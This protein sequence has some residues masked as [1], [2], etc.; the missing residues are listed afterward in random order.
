M[1]ITV[2]RADDVARRLTLYGRQLR[3][4]RS[5]WRLVARRVAAEERVW[6]A[7]EGRG[8]WAPLSKEYAAW[9]ARHYPGRPILVATGELRAAATS[10]ERLLSDR[11]GSMMT[12]RID[13]PKAAYHGGRQR[14][15]LLPRRDPSVPVAT[16]RRIAREAMRDHV[17]YRAGIPGPKPAA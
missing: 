1:R 14:S 8:T 5:L 2:T 3:T 10:S 6:F 17:R 16:L 11:A 13:D 4:W 7:S 15:G 12:L 9:K